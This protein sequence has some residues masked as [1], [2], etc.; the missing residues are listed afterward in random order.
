MAAPTKIVRFPNRKKLHLVWDASS[1]EAFAEP[2]RQPE[3]GQGRPDDAT[4][5]E[6]DRGSTGP[7][8]TD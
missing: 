2:T 8:S 3:I 6:R 4:L 7:E 5:P 1:V